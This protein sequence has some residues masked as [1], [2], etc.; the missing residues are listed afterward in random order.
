MASDTAS[1]PFVV[2]LHAVGVAEEHRAHGL[3][4]DIQLQLVTGP[5]PD[6]NGPGITPALKVAQRFLG[7][8]RRAVDAVHDLE[9][10]RASACPLRHAVQDPGPDCIGLG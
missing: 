3:A 9:R 7:Q 8:V 1:Q 5:V 4:V 6:P 10:A 2:D